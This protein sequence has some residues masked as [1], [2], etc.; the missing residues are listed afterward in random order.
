MPNP[1]N[2]LKQEIEDEELVR[3]NPY[4]TIAGGG[5]D[6]VG[7]RLEPITDRTN[8][9]KI[10]DAR[11]DANEVA[12][13]AKE[14]NSLGTLARRT[15]TG[16]PEGVFK[17][18]KAVITNPKE[19]ANQFALGLANGISFGATDAL[20]RKAFLDEAQ[21]HGM[22]ETTARSMAETML[23]P[24]DPALSGIRGGGSLAGMVV[25]YALAEGI[26]FN[27]IKY[28]APAFVAKHAAAAR[29]LANIGAWAPIGQIEESFKPE[30]ERNRLMRLALDVG[31]ATAFFAGGQIFRTLRNT[32]FKKPLFAGPK[33]NLP[34]A[35]Q[36]AIPRPN[37]EP[38]YY[39]VEAIKEGVPVFKWSKGQKAELY[40]MYKDIGQKY[41][42]NGTMGKGNYYA[43][44]PKSSS[45]FGEVMDDYL[46][47]QNIKVLDL[48]KGVEPGS[49]AA[50]YNDYL[51]NNP[52]YRNM[53]KETP[54]ADVLSYASSKGYQ[55][56]KF[57]SDDGSHYWLA[58]Q[59]GTRLDPLAHPAV[60]ALAKSE[61]KTNLPII[62]QEAITEGVKGTAANAVA[63]ATMTIEKGAARKARLEAEAEASKAAGAKPVP[64]NEKPVVAEGDSLTVAST[65]LDAL[66]NYIK[67]SGNIEY[68]VVNGGLGMDSAGRPILARHEYVPKTGQHVIYASDSTSAASLAHELGH[69]YDK[70]LTK[71][72]SGLARLLPDFTKNRDAIEDALASYSVARLGGTATSDAI[73]ADIKG[74]ADALVAESRALS[75]AR[76]A[77]NSKLSEQ[78]ADAVSQVLTGKGQQAPILSGLLKH[79]DELNETNLLGEKIAKSIK[80]D[81]ALK[82]APDNV[83]PVNGKFFKLEGE[84]LKKYTDAK[85]KSDDFLKGADKLKP[86]QASAL[87]K[88]EGMQLA[89]TKRE[90]TGDY[91]PNELNKLIA[92][93]Q[94]NFVGKK[95]EVKVNG[96]ITKGEVASGTAYGNVKI[97]LKNGKTISVKT[98]DIV[99]DNRSAQE[100]AE[101]LT[102]RKGVS[103][104][105][106]EEAAAKAAPKPKKPAAKET[107]EV[108]AAKETVVEKE[109]PK[110][111]DRQ[112]TGKK[113][114]TAPARSEL[115]TKDEEIETFFNT[116]VLTQVTGKERIGRS[117]DDV[118]A[119]SFS[120][121][122]TESDFNGILETRFGNLSGDVV[123]A[124]R[125]MNDKAMSIVDRTAGR[126]VDEIP[127]DELKEITSEMNQLVEMF[128]VMAGMRTELSNSFRSLGIAVA[129]GENDVLRQVVGE[130]QRVIGKDVSPFE[131]M[132]K[133]V[134]L[135]ESTILDKYFTIWYPAILSGPK[136]TARNIVGTGSNIISETLSHLFTTE[137]RMTFRERLNAMV[138]AQKGAWE[139]SKRIFKGEETMASKFNEAPPLKEPAFKGKFGWLNNVEYVGRFLD[140]QDAFLSTIAREGEVAALRAGNYSYGIRQGNGIAEKVN[141]GVAA[142]FGKRMTYRNEFDKTTVGEIG[143]I[144]STLK[145]SDNQLIKGV[146]TF[147]MPF[148]RT[149]ANVTDRKL[150]YIPI[151]NIAR[152]F[153][154]KIHISR[155]RSVARD[156]NLKQMLKE[157]YLAA[158]MEGALAARTASSET[159][160]IISIIATRLK[161]QQMGKFYMGLSVTASLA[162]LAMSG[163]ITGAG[164]K[165]KNERAT[166][167]QT[168]WRPQ[169]I[170]LPGGVV[171][172]YQNLGPLSGVLSM[173]GNMSDAAKY[174]NEDDAAVTE[175]FASGIGNFMR[176]EL[177]QSFLSG[178][179]GVVDLAYGFKTLDDFVAE[180]AASAIPIP[181][182]WTQTKDIV[183]QDRFEANNFLEQMQNKVGI[184]AGLEPKLNAFGEQY[185]SDLI[186]GLTPTLM[187]TDDPVLNWM[188]ENE[189]FIGKPSKGAKI[190]NR[191]G[192]EREMTPEEYTTFLE[193]TGSKVY[194]ELE[195][196]IS[197]GSFNRFKTEEEKRA[198][199]QK[200]VAE[201]RDKEKRH[202]TY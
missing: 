170:I 90:I 35:G 108:P 198:A 166:L 152:T 187:N 51:V 129:P 124:K 92:R 193:A 132:K 194:K 62:T 156:I 22:D 162:P 185:G 128:E 189:V 114:E 125:M 141:E 84:S 76:G 81:A 50:I 20:Q 131:V 23:K 115:I 7:S 57:F 48:T 77:G 101:T 46:L 66:Q 110:K 177:D 178:L 123:K 14:E 19:A 25:P 163:R 196:K 119:S 106:P 127:A 105:D 54:G 137:G 174:N 69:F 179:S 26:V 78:F 146:T 149:V 24:Q 47:P 111:L 148:V 186:W 40:Q 72:T 100:I 30:D 60:A 154:S 89:A 1:Y 4:K 172:P 143:K 34:Q 107:P 79:F 181:A 70:E 147:L 173:L 182:A 153:G 85:K 8:F 197:S 18:A 83:V 96:K 59:E 41:G 155:A 36:T 168:G 65:D 3:D 75:A 140:A 199:V 158:G 104:Y 134:K 29:Y 21:S 126:N 99:S 44:D 12:A 159:E 135:R 27:G 56:I 112:P 180:T 98:S 113:P 67:G 195:Q 53:L 39:N 161:Q 71:S 167:M 109:V 68:K 31:T 74:V 45:M 94:S 16:T 184:T 139:N 97:K 190:K 10:A 80:N 15:V 43:Y 63:R 169:S 116:K 5:S 201:I 142:A 9:R 192:D 37:V 121:K 130:I 42:Q 2:V 138:G 82:D 28:A 150:D 175:I 200:I 91:T 64:F 103:L 164:P 102:K 87:R 176:G 122:M 49:T 61:V 157:D 17:V 33:T 88:R 6:V 93:E 120:S 32:A 188:T 118:I 38:I 55:G 117:N 73:S 191:A 144:A 133:M 11:R 183:F 13:R 58:L 165:D 202:I 160:R 86:D 136:T 95:V 171:L 145:G 151:L 52:F